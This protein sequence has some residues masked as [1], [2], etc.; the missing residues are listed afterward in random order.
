M[1]N[2][3]KIYVQFKKVRHFDHIDLWLTAADEMVNN[4]L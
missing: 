2:K 1:C 3:N 4:P